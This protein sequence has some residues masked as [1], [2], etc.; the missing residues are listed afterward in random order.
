MAA[1]ALAVPVVAASQLD[2]LVLAE[3]EA[4]LDGLAGGCKWD[5]RES[6]RQF[7]ALPAGQ[8]RQ[9]ACA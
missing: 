8:A 3:F 4:G 5:L 7:R 9:P 1:A 2:P 6:M